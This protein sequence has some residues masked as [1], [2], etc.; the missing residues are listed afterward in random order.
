MTHAERMSFIAACD[1]WIKGIEA[2]K[3]TAGPEARPNSFSCWRSAVSEPT[4][5]ERDAERSLGGIG[6]LPDPLTASWSRNG[7]WHCGNRLGVRSGPGWF[8][9]GDESDL[10]ANRVLEVDERPLV[11]QP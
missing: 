8:L 1:A 4:M 7:K 6:Y 10:A 11:R 3:K 2:A 9:A 5:T